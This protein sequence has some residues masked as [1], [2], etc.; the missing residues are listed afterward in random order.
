[1]PHKPSPRQDKSA[2]ADESKPPVRVY[3]VADAA[4]FLR[5]SIPQIRALV[6]AGRLEFIRNPGRR[7]RLYFDLLT[8]ERHLASSTHTRGAARGSPKFLL[9]E[10]TVSEEY[11]LSLAQLRTWRKTGGGP[12]FLRIGRNIRYERGD[13]EMFL[14]SLKRTSEAAD[15]GREGGD[16]GK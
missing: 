6:R 3:N 11:G 5:V 7:S 13:V 10:K 1:M 15:P 8:L 12:P 2:A 14:S 16:N 4:R 9:P